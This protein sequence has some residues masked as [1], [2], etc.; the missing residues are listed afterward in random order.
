MHKQFTETMY[1]ELSLDQ[2]E[3]RENTNNMYSACGEVVRLAW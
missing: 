3:Y 1:I 2:Y